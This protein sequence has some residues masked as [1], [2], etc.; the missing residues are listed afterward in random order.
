MP[1]LREEPSDTE[2]ISHK[3]LVRAGMIRKVAGGI[4]TY[5]PLA[6]RVLQKITKIVREEMDKA[7]DGSGPAHYAASRIM[8]QTGRWQLYGDEMFRLKDRHQ[9]DFCLGPTHERL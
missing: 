2:V 1:T 9:R 5:L 3:L 4:Y 7:G 6:F 8:D